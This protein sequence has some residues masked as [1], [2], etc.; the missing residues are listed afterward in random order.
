MSDS[1]E[2]GNETLNEC[3][4]GLESNDANRFLAN[5]DK[6]L[7]EEIGTFLKNQEHQKYMKSFLDQAN[8]QLDRWGRDKDSDEC[9][10]K[11]L[12]DYC[13]VYECLVNISKRCGIGEDDFFHDNQDR[14]MARWL[15][16]AYKAIKDKD[17]SKAKANIMMSY[18]LLRKAFKEPPVKN[19]APKER[20]LSEAYGFKD[21][22]RFLVKKSDYDHWRKRY[23]SFEKIEKKDGWTK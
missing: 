4:K 19:S 20:N 22:D 18:K 11:D 6:F 10:D 16:K 14:L 1:G 9:L 15:D 12:G 2:F 3:F 23:N 5:A 7:N 13:R 17:R 8:L 21:S